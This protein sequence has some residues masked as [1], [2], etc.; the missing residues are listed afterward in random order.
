MIRRPLIGPTAENIGYYM[1]FISN[2]SRDLIFL[3]T[4]FFVSV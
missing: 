2:I 3:L 4:I 1:D